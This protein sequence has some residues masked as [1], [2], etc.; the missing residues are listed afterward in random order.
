MPLP[1]RLALPVA[2]ATSFT[3]ACSHSSDTGIDRPDASPITP[4]DA[5]S[6][7][8]S[9]APDDAGTTALQLVVEPDQGMTPIYNFVSSAK[10]TIDMTMYELNDDTFTGLLTS[11]AANGIVVRVILDTNLEG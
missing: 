11:A 4:V 8:A 9:A 10:K 7:G 6:D 5:S 3:L 1:S 2:L